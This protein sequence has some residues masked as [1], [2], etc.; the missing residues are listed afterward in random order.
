MKIDTEPFEG[1][2]I[3]PQK[4]YMIAD[5]RYTNGADNNFVEKLLKNNNF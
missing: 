2:F 4:P 1:E 3:S 5:V